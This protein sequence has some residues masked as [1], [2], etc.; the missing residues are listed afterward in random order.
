VSGFTR[1]YTD[2]AL[3][4]LRIATSTVNGMVG[5]AT[6]N[7]TPLSD[8]LLPWRVSTDL[9]TW[10]TTRT[11]RDQPQ[12]AHPSRV[13]RYWPL[14]RLRDYSDP[15]GAAVLPTVVLPPQ[16][17]HDSCIVDYAPGQSQLLTLRAAGLERLYCLDWIGAEV[18]DR[19][20]TD[21]SIEDYL[22]VLDNTV[23][24]LGG[25]VNL[26]G[27]C[28][29]GWLAAIYAALHPERVNTL[30]VAGAPIDCHAG[31]SPLLDW[32]RLIAGIGRRSGLGELA[33]YRASVALGGGVAP[34]FNQLLGFK[35][36]RPTSEWDRD[37]ALLAHIRDPEYV[38]R[39][40]EF[41]DWFEWTQDLPG[42]FYLWIVEHL[43][44]GNELIAGELTIG[45]RR[46]DLGAIDC[47]VFLIAGAS[48]HITPPEQ[49]WALAEQVN[50]PV[51]RELV[52]GGHLGLFM[53]REAL[54][55]HWAPLMAR[56]RKLS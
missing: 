44:L 54:R 55:E 21:A 46:V 39:H 38:A 26:V 18:G 1:V 8:P 50:G 53:G 24:L 51:H 7:L 49:V 30:T 48:D 36:L 47:P 29:G 32:T 35:M 56:V 11:V 6:R 37:M 22:A 2:L 17:G 13:I 3:T 5:Y 31:K 28:Q 14:A 52:H 12:W 25:Q 19:A 10:W 16:A 23:E 15:V 41:A 27:D 33:W 34:G 42:Q 43:F 45:D 40:A 4:P 20:T 9:A